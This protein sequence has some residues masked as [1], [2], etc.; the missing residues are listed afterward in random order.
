ME[1]FELI[2]DMGLRHFVE[3][4]VGSLSQLKPFYDSGEY[5]KITLIEVLP[6]VVDEVK[7]YFIG[8]GV[9]IINKGVADEHGELDFYID[10]D[11]THI[12]NLPSSPVHFHGR[13]YAGVKQKLQV[14]R[15]SEIEPERID[16]LAVDIEGA[17]WFVLKYMKN[18]P[19]I[20]S[21][22][23]HSSVTEY[24]NPYSENIKEWME[25]NGYIVINKGVS[26]TIYKKQ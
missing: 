12:V 9:E 7:K 24:R 26:D 19:L 18:R 21:L 5:D 3:V 13:E 17:E 15:F 8:G 23:T 20:I 6:N 16:L 4:G 14:V 2:K 22:E 1:L 11:C 25:I 10:G